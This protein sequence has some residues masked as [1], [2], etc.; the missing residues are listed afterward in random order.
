MYRFEYQE[1]LDNLLIY[2]DIEAGAML[3]TTATKYGSQVAVFDLT[4]KDLL[5]LLK[6]TA[7]LVTEGH[8]KEDK[9]S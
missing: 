1:G 6:L 5:E 4:K 2:G 3:T 9:E 7:R 8:G